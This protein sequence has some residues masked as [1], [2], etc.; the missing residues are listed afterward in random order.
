[1]DV[2]SGRPIDIRTL[3]GGWPAL[4]DGLTQMSER[5]KELREKWE[6]KNPIKSKV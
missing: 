2:K 6:S 3:G 5:A 4:Y 1:M